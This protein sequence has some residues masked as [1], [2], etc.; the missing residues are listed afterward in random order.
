LVEMFQP[1]PVAS[2]AVVSAMNILLDP[3]LCPLYTPSH[4]I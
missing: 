2:R 1:S 3:L 4:D